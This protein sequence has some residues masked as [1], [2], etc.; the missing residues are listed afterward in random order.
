MPWS[1]AG[2][3]RSPSTLGRCQLVFVLLVEDDL[4]LC[5]TLLAGLA[6]EQCQVDVVSDGDAALLALQQTPY[7]VCILDICLPKQ[8]GFSVLAAARRAA[9]RTPIL[10]LTARDAVADRVRGLTDGADDY[11]TKPFAFAE[12]LAR[13]RALVR[14]GGARHGDVIVRGELSVCLSA[15]QVQVGGAVVELTPKQFAILAMLLRYEGEVVTRAMLLH[16]IWGYTFDPGTNV[17]DVH[18][19]QLRRKLEQ[20]GAMNRIHTVRGMGYR[21]PREA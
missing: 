10:I 14:R 20:A 18:V 11:L 9:V 7:D 15:H 4:R 8:D 5:R 16:S 12:L 2:G 17:V 3:L 13:L 6:E 19:A 21:A 1:R